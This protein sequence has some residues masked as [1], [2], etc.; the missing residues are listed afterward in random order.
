MKKII[1]FWLIGTICAAAMYVVGLRDENLA[2][3]AGCASFGLPSVIFVVSC[4]ILGKIP[5]DSELIDFIHC[6]IFVAATAVIEYYIVCR[7]MANCS[8]FYSVPTA[9]LAG[10]S[11][12][13]LAENARKKLHQM[14]RFK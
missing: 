12:V 7:L 8:L 5:K 3:A 2:L 11:M 9:L 14:S 10:A 13:W 4:L 1:L 6:W